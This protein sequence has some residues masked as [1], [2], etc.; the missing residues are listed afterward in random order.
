MLASLSSS[1]YHNSILMYFITQHLSLGKTTEASFCFTMAL[2]FFFGISTKT[3]LVNEE[4]QVHREYTM[5]TTQSS[6]QVTMFD[7]I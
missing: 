4:G 5:G 6:T 1:V 2:F 7:Q 3:L